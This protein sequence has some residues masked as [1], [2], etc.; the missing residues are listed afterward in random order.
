MRQIKIGKGLSPKTAVSLYARLAPPRLTPKG[1]RRGGGLSK[2]R[3]H[4][5]WVIPKFR[6]RRMRVLPPPTPCKQGRVAGE[7]G[8]IEGCFPVSV[9]QG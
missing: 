6:E 3:V 7:P 5:M 9:S 8:E 4:G 2:T 1:E